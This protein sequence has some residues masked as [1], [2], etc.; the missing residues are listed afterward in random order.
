MNC[1]TFS[2][3]E[4]S[5][6]LKWTLM[7]NRSFQMLPSPVQVEKRKRTCLGWSVVNNGTERDEV[8]VLW[9]IFRKRGRRRRKR[10]NSTRVVLEKKQHK[11]KKP[12][13]LFKQARLIID[14]LVS[15]SRTHTR[16]RTPARTHTHTHFH[17]Q[18]LQLPPE[19]QSITIRQ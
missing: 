2:A 18:Q 13:L 10:K 19:P 12:Q 16:P 4:G 11:M 14:W 17:S 3:A 8:T 15:G 7:S 1:A 9:I 5:K 6:E